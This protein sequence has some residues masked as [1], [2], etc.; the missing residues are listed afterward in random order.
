MELFL[1][2]NYYCEH[3]I[4][5]N[6]VEKKFVVSLSNGLFFSLSSS[7]LVG[8]QLVKTEAEGVLT[9]TNKWSG[10]ISILSLSSV[11]GLGILNHYPDSGLEKYKAVFNQ[12]IFPRGLMKSSFVFKGI[13]LKF[14]S[15]QITLFLCFLT[16]RI[17]PHLRRNILIPLIR[18]KDLLNLIL[19][20]HISIKLVLKK[21][22]LLLP[23]Q[24]IQ[25][26]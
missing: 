25:Q 22:Y 4:L 6:A 1:N 18:I 15:S 16:L 7:S 13:I 21:I 2:A 17:A 8:E 3:P 11:L 24:L 23:I 10:F 19:F 9:S 20:L 5:A 14:L 26:R 12:E